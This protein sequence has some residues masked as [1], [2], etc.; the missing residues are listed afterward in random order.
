MFNEELENP[1][2]R[3]KGQSE[4][5]KWTNSFRCF[6]SKKCKFQEYAM[7]LERPKLVNIRK[8]NQYGK[9]KK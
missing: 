4:N 8:K 1:S 3:Y 2:I 5:A 7:G 9:T 6:Q